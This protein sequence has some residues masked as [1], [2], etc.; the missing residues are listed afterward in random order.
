MKTGTPYRWLERCVAPSF[1]DDVLLRC[2]TTSHD[3]SCC[4]GT[5]M[6][7]RGVAIRGLVPLVLCASAAARMP[8]VGKAAFANHA[9]LCSSSRGRRG[10]PLFPKGAHGKRLWGRRLP[11]GRRDIDSAGA[12]L[13]FSSSAAAD[14]NSADDELDALV[15][16]SVA[17]LPTR[18]RVAVVGGVF[19]ES[20]SS[21][22]GGGS[23]KCKHCCTGNSSA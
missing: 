8:L 1:H 21:S 3:D 11:R 2:L 16:T 23:F 15:K 20:Y 22:T 12:A 19:D 9:M 5:P 18:P 10:S 14:G 7:Q 13:R 4:R 6:K 17:A